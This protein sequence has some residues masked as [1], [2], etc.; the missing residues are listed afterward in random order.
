MNTIMKYL[1]SMPVMAVLLI[2]FALSCAVATF[3]E[4]DF[5]T[6]TAWAVIYASWWFEF[7]Q[8]LLGINLFYNILYFK[9]Y[10]KEKLP[11]FIFHISLLFILV[12]AGLTRYLGY[13]GT[14]HIRENRS[15]NTVKSNDPYIQIKAYKD[16]VIYGADYKKFISKIGKNDFE[17]YFGVK[18]KKAKVEFKEYVPNAVSTIADDQNG[19]PLIS[20]AVS[21]NDKVDEIVLK[22]GDII[23]VDN[24]IFSFNKKEQVSEKTYVRF[25]LQ[26]GEFFI[27]SDKN[28]NWFKMSDNTKGEYEKNAKQSFSD[29]YL[30]TVEGINFAAK[31]TG[32]KGKQKIVSA[33]GEVRYKDALIVSVTYNDI[34]EESVLFGLGR[35][36]KGTPA[37]FLIDDAA[38]MMEW[39]S[40][41]FRLPFSIMLNDFQLERYPGSNSPS[42][43]ASEITLL[44]SAANIQMPYKIYMN[45]VLDYKGYRFFQASYDQDEG[46]SVLSVNKDP[47][48][49][50]TYIGY[51]L[52]TLG[53]LLNIFNPKSR[54]RKL[55]SQI[56]LA[57]EDKTATKKMGKTLKSVSVLLCTL[58]ILSLAPSLKAQNNTTDDYNTAEAKGYFFDNSTIDKYT[59]TQE[60]KEH[61]K[62]FGTILAQSMDGRIY[63]IDTISHEI[64]NKVRRSDSYNGMNANEILF[65]MI[66]NPRAWQNEP[67]IRISH[68]ELKK[69]LNING[70]YAAFKDFFDAQTNEY[71]LQKTVEIAERKKESERNQFDKDVIKVDER[72]NILFS[73]FT[74]DI[75]KIIPKIDDENYR[76]HSL[77]SAMYTFPEDESSNIRM[78]FGIYFESIDAASKSGNWTNANKMAETIKKY[79]QA[80]SGDIIPTQTKIKAEIFFNEA[81]IFDRIY[82][83]YLLSGFVLL[84]FI[85]IKMASS[86]FNI[87]IIVKTLF[88]VN[89]F[90]FIIHTAGL[91]LRWYIAEHAPWSNSY[92]SMIYIAWAIALAGLF[93]ARTSVISMSLTY[94]MAGI[95][96]FTAHLSWMDPQIT[97]LMPVLKSH[98]LTIHVSVITASYG[99]LGL[100]ALLGFFVL[101]LQ[102]IRGFSKNDAHKAEIEKNITEAIKIN[103]MSMILGLSL[104]SVGNFLGG[105]WA[106]ESWGRYWGWD[107]KETWALISILVYAA[108]VHF[109]FIPRLNNQF[110]FAVASV[111]AYFSI[112]MTYFGVNFYLSG[113]HSYASGDTVP[114][115]MFIWIIIA[116]IAITVTIAA[117]FTMRDKQS[118]KEL[119]KL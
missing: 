37:S 41:E 10:K 48:K 4:N 32:T 38:F 22:E 50:P 75:F 6:Q 118:G 16:G 85:F 24:T 15:E 93:F 9:L 35:G 63:P 86:K 61:A 92:E 44:D 42:S 89:L 97:N 78:L 64:L 12:G 59:I 117:I 29:K 111:L 11:A 25:I 66:N 84:V 116:I 83:V 102:I 95:T 26:E 58:A 73:T 91:A 98:W 100:C 17:F 5:G 96:L 65:N 77:N 104:L 34:T 28:I 30:Y 18:D 57:R 8:V 113:M 80:Y 110:A 101:A 112:I 21:N 52:L 109:R 46:G 70:S 90:T 119:K 2:I 69:L 36:Y 81:K 40:K 108:I 68:K 76:W 79:Q 71:K 13:E 94:I 103:E 14:L 106:N 55:S 47:G 114:V 20:L 3:I 115:P 60:A 45:H 99:F 82:I 74:M 67:I 23:E 105:I 43:Y 56:N 53:L 62:L 87:N 49:L 33:E 7:I 1:F 39:G 88:A 31:Y 72:V 54:F 51:F 107:P 19:E 27:L